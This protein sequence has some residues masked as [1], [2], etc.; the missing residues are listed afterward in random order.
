[1]SGLVK[2]G[3]APLT[4]SSKEIAERTGKRHDHVIRD[5]RNLVEAIGD[6]PN[7]GDVVE[8]KDGRG[9]TAEFLLPKRETLILV[10]G[11]DTRLR[12]AII[13]RWQELE[14]AAATPPY[15]SFAAS[16]DASRC[17]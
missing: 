6:A 5:I 7:L 1:M 8:I 9:Y 4:M 11:Y 10:S 2:A 13:D 3:A 12:A 16:F 14:Q 15:P 17:V